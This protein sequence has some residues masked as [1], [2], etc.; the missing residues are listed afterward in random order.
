MFRCKECGSEYEV[1][2]EYCDCGN[3]TFV[4]VIVQKPVSQAA[5]NVTVQK[6]EASVRPNVYQNNT[7]TPEPKRHKSF[8]EQ[9]PEFER[10]KQKFDPIATIVFLFCVILSVIVLFFVGNPEEKT[11]NTTNKPQ[12]AEVQKINIPQIDTFWNN[13]TAGIINNEKSK[14]KYAAQASAASTNSTESIL[15]IQSFWWK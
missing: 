12:P 3:D 2:P 6:S 13:S 10:M 9:Y 5:P 15:N 1:K 11:E 14:Q 7:R 8:S 4:E